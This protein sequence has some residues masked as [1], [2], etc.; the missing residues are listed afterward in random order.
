MSCERDHRSRRRG[1]GQTDSPSPLDKFTFGLW[2]VGNPGRDPFGDRAPAARPG[3]RR[4][5][6]GRARRLRRQ[7]PRQRPRADRRHAAERDRI[8]RD[9]RKA[10]D[11]PAWSC[12]WRPRTSSP[13]RC[14]RTAPSRRTTPRP[15][16]RRPEDDAGDRPRRGAGRADLRVLGRTRGRRDDA[17]K[18]PVEAIKWFREA[19]DFLC[20]YAH[21]PA[22]RASV[23]ARGQ[24]ERA[25]RRHLFPDHGRLP[26][27]HPD[28]ARIPRWSA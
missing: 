26:G 22:V 8:V 20:E 12:R 13:T 19:I 9:F 16:L 27:L 25:A 24:A 6:A 3:G 5:H 14:S 21:R 18:D 11:A 23:R 1:H 17:A 10:L 4:A 28:A 15:R 2:T 7:L